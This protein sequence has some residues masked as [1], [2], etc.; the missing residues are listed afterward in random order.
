MTQLY[1]KLNS[2]F[3]DTSDIVFFQKCIGLDWVNPHHVVHDKKIIDEELWN[4]SLE[5]FDQ[6]DREKYPL[7]KIHAF[8]ETSKIIQ[9]SIIFCS[10]EE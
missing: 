5:Y 10:W 7:K 8:S 3:P 1:R 4:A 6:M 2:N 9:N